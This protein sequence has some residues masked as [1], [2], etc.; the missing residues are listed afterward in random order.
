MKKCVKEVMLAKQPC[1]N[2]ECRLYLDFEE[3]LN[4]SQ[5]HSVQVLPNGNILFFDNHRYLSPELSRCME[6]K[7]NEFDYSTELVWEHVLPIENFTGSRGECDRLEN[8][9]TLITA[10]RS[11]ATFEVTPNNDVVWQL[12]VQNFNIDVT[13]YRSARIP[14]LYPV[15]FS[16]SIDNLFIENGNNYVEPINDIVNVNIHNSGWGESTYIYQ[17]KDEFN[18][19]ILS[20]SVLMNSYEDVSFDINTNNLTTM[21]LNLEVFP[22]IA[23]EKL[24]L[25]NFTISG[26]TLLGDMNSDGFINILDI[27]ILS[28]NILS[29]ENN[30]I[31]DMNQDS[32]INILDIVILVNIILGNG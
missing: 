28:N 29:N 8:G 1:C 4:F 22:I 11:G 17:V 12:K 6:V 7:Y 27:V 16:L 24:E 10:G 19:I 2:K 15:A 9:N 26:S 3:D 18:N 14:N 31:G 20:D 5:Q 23:P 21:N 13:M 25:I 32:Y 30:S